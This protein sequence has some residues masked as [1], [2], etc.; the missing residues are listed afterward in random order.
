M[1]PLKSYFR[2]PAR[3]PESAGGVVD[4]D[5]VVVVIIMAGVEAVLFFLRGSAEALV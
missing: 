3:G 5:D 2:L 1:I 4:A